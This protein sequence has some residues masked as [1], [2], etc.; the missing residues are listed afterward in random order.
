MNYTIYDTETTGLH[1]RYDYALTF[2]AKTVDENFNIIDEINLQSKLRPGILPSVYAIS[3]N[4]LKISDLNKSELSFYEMTKKIYNYFK[5][6]SPSFII[7]HNSLNFDEEILRSHFYQCLFPIFTTQ[8]NGNLRGD[9]LII[10]RAASAFSPGTIK[11]DLNKNGKPD[12][13]LEGISTANNF[14]HYDAHTAESDV[15][16]CLEILKKIK[17]Y[18]NKFFKACMQTTSKKGVNEFVSKNLAFCFLKSIKKQ[19]VITSCAKFESFYLGFDLTNNPDEFIDLSAENLV[20]Y[21]KKNNSPFHIIKNNKQPIML[22]LSYKKYT[23]CN[24][25]DEE[26]LLRAN[27]IKSNKKF[28]N[29]I[30]SAFE[31]IKKEFPVGETIEEQIFLGGF[32]NISDKNLI[33]KFHKIDWYERVALISKFKDTRFKEIGLRLIY[34]QNPYLLDNKSIEL[35]EKIFHNRIYKKNNR[36]RSLQQTIT[37]FEDYKE[38]NPGMLKAHM[39]EFEKYIKAI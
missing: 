12:F 35:V 5:K 10:A 13:S 33:E 8:L 2:S 38:K 11:I 29:S 7:G 28:I 17:N 3:T 22:D 23:N 1:Y 9:T 15:I 20:K 26:I 30:K 39:A 34:E 27:K 31:L 32:P 21:F 36:P 19:I 24:L 16:A 4:K 25:L 6:N 37:E 14:N 18:D